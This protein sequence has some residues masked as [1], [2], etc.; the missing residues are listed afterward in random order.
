MTIIMYIL[1]IYIIM[2]CVQYITHIHTVAAG[3][4]Y[5]FD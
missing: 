5:H 4:V 1:E 2:I 3:V